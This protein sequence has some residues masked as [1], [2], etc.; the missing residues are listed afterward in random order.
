MCV[1][2]TSVRSALIPTWIEFVF[3]MGTFTSHRGPTE[4]NAT[5]TVFHREGNQEKHSKCAKS[6]AGKKHSVF[7]VSRRHLI[8]LA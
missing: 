4:V 2:L 5:Y 7:P 8:Q 1:H 3:P 6:T